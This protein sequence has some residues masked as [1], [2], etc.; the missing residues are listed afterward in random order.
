MGEALQER[1]YGQLS[2]EPGE[3]AADANVGVPAKPHVAIV[4]AVDIEPIGVLELQ[5][6]AVC[7]SDYECDRRP[8]REV[9]PSLNSG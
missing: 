3:C 2:L 6:V 9:R 4:F 1:R 7:G 5:R 8:G